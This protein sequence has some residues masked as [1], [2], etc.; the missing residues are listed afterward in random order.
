[1][2]VTVS[3]DST[4]SYRRYENNDEV[5]GSNMIL[6]VDTLPTSSAPPSAIMLTHADKGSPCYSL[7]DSDDVMV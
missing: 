7:F 2:L 6:I 5:P 1:M 3:T 4:K